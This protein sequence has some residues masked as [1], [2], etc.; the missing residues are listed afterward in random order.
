M[1]VRMVLPSGT[2]W[3][4]VAFTCAI[5][6]LLI[7]YG[8]SVIPIGF[9][10][11]DDGF[12]LA[13]A[14]AIL[15]GQIPHVDLVSP[16]PVGSPVLHS[17]TYFA[18]TPLLLTS[19]ALVFVQLLIA[20][21][22]QLRLLRDELDRT[23]TLTCATMLALVSFVLSTHTFPLQAWH[24]IDGVFF[25]S[26]GAVMTTRGAQNDSVRTIA[27]GS[28]VAGTAAIVK[29][30]FFPIVLL[31]PVL[32]ILRYRTAE[33]RINPRY[34]AASVSG[35]TAPIVL[36][37]VATAVF[38]GTSSTQQIFSARPPRRSALVIQDL[39]VQAVTLFALIAALITLRLPGGR[40]ARRLAGLN[41]RVVL[42][43]FQA[44]I[45][46]R[47]VVE[48][49][50]SRLELYGTWSATIWW[51]ARASTAV[52]TAI[53][54]SVPFAALLMLALGAMASLSW[55]Y[56]NPS[57]TA[58]GLFLIIALSL[59]EAVRNVLVAVP[60]G[61]SLEGRARSQTRPLLKS[62]AAVVVVGGLLWVS[63]SLRAGTVYRDVSRGDQTV[64]LGEISGDL[65]GLRS[66]ARMADVLRQ[67]R[68][69]LIEY[70]S[71]RLAIVPDGAIIPE[72]FG[73]TN[74]LPVAWWYP[75]EVVEERK[76]ILERVSQVTT[77][78]NGH[79]VLFQTFPIDQLALRPA[80]L[81]TVDT[82]L[83]DYANGFANDLF[84]SI[85]GDVVACGGFVG[86]HLSV[87]DVSER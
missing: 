68:D 71:G 1:G 51:L 6:A 29:Q 21:W 58:G 4:G 49:A 65:H 27:F 57:L 81:A 2:R 56:A 83:F 7:V 11:T 64:T 47:C 78:G 77:S 50:G 20:A 62:F 79:L 70:P 82:P 39:P 36:Y 76:R 85:P 16:R 67:V 35:A 19:R 66:N 45:A 48:I 73:T 69:C 33:G 41:G 53:R 30:S 80:G 59:F 43:L 18:P 40:T 8:M 84:M 17:L 72:L 63:F 9:N 61:L 31:L 22:A 26:L 60:S 55:G 37:V 87:A 12:I 52:W 3:G 25:V 15:S 38:G 44:A 13:Q 28:V 46:V 32:V 10:A 75:P 5:A 24:T 42:A 54:R 23:M 14:A 86:R 74:P 34:F